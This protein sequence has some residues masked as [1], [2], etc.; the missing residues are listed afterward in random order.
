MRRPA[1]WACLPVAL[2]CFMLVF[3]P[4]LCAGFGEFTIRDEQELARKFDLIIE[5]RFPV[6]QDT[7][8]SGYVQSVVDKLVA[9]MPPQPFPVHVTVVRNGGLN[10]F[11]SAAGHITVFTGLIANLA[12]EDE[13]ASVLAHEMAHVSERHIAKSIEKSQIVGIGSLLGML[14]GILVGTQGGGGDGAGAVILGTMAGAQ[15]M[16]LQYTRENER[17]ADE[18]GLGFLVGAGYGPTGMMRAFEKIRKLQ[19]LSGG[20]DVPSYLSTHPGMEER[21]SYI[22]DRISKLPQAERDRVSANEAFLRTKLLVQAWYTDPNTAFAFFTKGQA[23]RPACQNT[24]G[25]AIALSRLHQIE[26]ARVEFE[27]AKSC[28]P[29]DALWIR[30]YGRFAFDYGSLDVAVRALQEAVLKQPDDL[31]AVFYYARAMA[32]KGSYDTALKSMQRV[33][34]AV[35]R[36]S[37]VLEFLGQYEAALGHALDAHM[38]YAKAFA[39]KRQFSKYEFHLRKAMSLASSA[40]EKDRI[41]ALENEISEFRQILKS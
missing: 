29:Q 2:C 3:P 18:Y 38:N 33:S 39:Y 14:A 11:A 25:Q 30:E 36:D 32:E 40:V 16:Q 7:R 31:F 26:A 1:P 37:E 21:A 15:S 17:D 19:W 5:T 35:P 13:L 12:D 27:R 24:L 28:N 22:Q 6:V 10:A 41:A 23:D 34:R 4:R 8:I 9:T 20:G